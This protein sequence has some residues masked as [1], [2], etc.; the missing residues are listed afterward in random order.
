MTL[1]HAA[2]A[3]IAGFAFLLALLTTSSATKQPQSFKLS[4]LP[5][6]PA[7]VEPSFEAPP[8]LGTNFYFSD[9]PDLAQGALATTSRQ[10]EVNSRVS[11][12]REHL[13]AGKRFY[14][15]D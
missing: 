13:E 3:P 2:L 15:L 11:K 9:P 7:P 6:T 10:G 5:S 8:H 4:F 12:A 1:R 14:Q